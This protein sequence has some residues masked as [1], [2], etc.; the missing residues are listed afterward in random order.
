MLQ[1]FKQYNKY[2]IRR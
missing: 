2:A 1:E